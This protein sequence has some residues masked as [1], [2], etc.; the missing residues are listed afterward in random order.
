MTAMGPVKAVR[1]SLGNIHIVAKEVNGEVLMD[2]PQGDPEIHSHISL[3]TFDRHGCVEDDTAH[4]GEWVV[5]KEYDGGHFAVYSDKLFL[6]RIRDKSEFKREEVTQL[7]KTAMTYQDMITSRGG[8]IEEGYSTAEFVAL[9]IER[10][11]R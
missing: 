4:I 8:E 7:I 3:K 10:L 2:I 6:A 1:V 5:V 11:L 9:Q